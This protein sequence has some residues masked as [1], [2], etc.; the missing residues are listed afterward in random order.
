MQKTKY[1][2]CFCHSILFF[3][4]KRCKIKFN[5]L[6]GY[7]NK[8]I[9][10][11]NIATDHSADIDYQDFKK[12]YRECTKVPYNFLTIDTTLPASD[13]LRFRKKLVDS[14]KNESN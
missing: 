12:S 8:T 14:P 2:T 13:P 7:K 11:K 4:S 5:T 1:L 6:F 10:L 9:E 3:C